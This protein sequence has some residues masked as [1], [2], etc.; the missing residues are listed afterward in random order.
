[1]EFHV[2]R[3]GT[4]KTNPKLKK[5]SKCRRYKAVERKDGSR[6]FYSDK[7]K[8]DGLTTACVSCIQ[9]INQKNYIKRTENKRRIPKEGRES[10]NG[11][12]NF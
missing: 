7:S 4:K 5:C 9:K 2:S 3:K 12:R 8:I 10:L 6:G 1:M 11:Q